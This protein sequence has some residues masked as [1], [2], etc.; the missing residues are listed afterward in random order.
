LRAV[1]DWADSDCSNPE[2]LPSP[3]IAPNWD[4]V[5]GNP[6]HS[7]ATCRPEQR[8]PLGTWDT[9]LY[10]A[11]RG[12]GKTRAAAEEVAKAA[13]TNYRWRIAILA[14]TYGDARDTCVEGESGLVAVFE[15]W[16]WEDG[17]E[18]TWNRSLGELTL[19]DTKSRFKLYSAE[20]P[21][22]LR[23]PQHHM[24]WVEELAQVVLNAADAW[25]MAKFG[26]RLGKHP[27]VVA[28]TTP[29]PVKLI[30]DLLTD[31]RC[32]VSRGT[33]YDNA[34]NLAAPALASLREAYE[35]KRLGRQELGG[36]L[37]D[38]IPGALW[39]RAWMD[40]HRIPCEE[41]TGDNAVEA[42]RV[43]RFLAVKAALEAAGI[44][45][46]RV[47]IGVDP[48]VTSGEDA[49]ETGIIVGGLG[50]DGHIYILEDASLRASPGVV[51][52]RVIE[53]YDRWE[54]NLVVLEVN[55][56]GEYIPAELKSS[57]KLL[58]RSAAAIKTH[59][60]R[61]K[62]GKRVRAEPVSNLYEPDREKGTAP[63]VRH[64]GTFHHTEDQLC[65]AGGELVHTLDGLK[66]IETVTTQDQVMTRA[67][68]RRVLWSGQTG[69]RNC[70]TVTTV[71]GAAVTC[72]PDHPLWVVG[73]GWTRA[74]EVQPGC[75]V[76]S[77][78]APSSDPSRTSTVS[79]TTWTAATTGPVDPEGGPS[80]IGMSGNIITA[81]SRTAG[82]STMSTTTR[83]TTTS[84]TCTPAPPPNTSPTTTRA[85]SEPGTPTV[86]GAKCASP[87]QPDYPEPAPA[88]T[89]VESSSRPGSAPSFAAVPVE[90]V[91]ITP[92]TARP[93]YDLTVAGQ[94]EFYAGGI[95]VHNCTWEPKKVESPDRMDALVY[96]VLY[97]DDSHSGTEVL[98]TVASIPRHQGHPGRA[99]IPTTSVRR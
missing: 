20:K 91:S 12:A 89:V 40:L 87:G 15:R 61:A 54:A 53:V 28:T 75:R 39:Q 29:L 45:I 25:D 86:G 76:L 51:M 58:G 6:C 77:C 94:P 49:D 82:M 11:G 34:A 78:P 64:V 67:G 16:G 38:D 79:A 73:Q 81:P 35:G 33:T 65:I 88:K 44:T 22:R 95:L 84:T 63:R 56:G 80:C 14:P 41:I 2:R 26:L 68:W 48:A 19:R 21:A 99:S 93:V 50:S 90:V 52:D 9:W 83:P 24:L 60:I 32:A 18:Y 96:V 62:K 98:R 4:R 74:D 71:S 46:L 5:P 17:R 30:R 23:G 8:A 97:L 37:L 47:V 69:H 36:E 70:V 55:N 10:L 1:R 13:A 66:P 27:K 57:L 59:S 85:D 31:E 7:C 43:A 72:T 3:E 92:A 42:V